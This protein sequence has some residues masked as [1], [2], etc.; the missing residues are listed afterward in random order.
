L[1]PFA[2]DNFFWKLA[3]RLTITVLRNC[4]KI[5]HQ[6]SLYT[7]VVTGRCWLRCTQRKWPR[8]SCVQR[9]VSNANRTFLFR[10]SKRF[11]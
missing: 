10:N 3:R 5:L 8:Y 4:T 6:G 1:S 2:V 9:S 7:A 11:L